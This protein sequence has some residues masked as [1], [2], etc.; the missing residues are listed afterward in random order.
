MEQL[1]I[2]EL[3]KDFNDYANQTG[4]S[5]KIEIAFAQ[6]YKNAKEMQS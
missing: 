6:T 2:Q 4:D 1:R 5:T 3:A